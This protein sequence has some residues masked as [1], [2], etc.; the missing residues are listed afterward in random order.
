MPKRSC[1]SALENTQDSLSASVPPRFLL[2]EEN[3][4]SK[5]VVP[6]GFDPRCRWAG[7]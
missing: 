2:T 6:R 7:G 3:E 1:S 4:E 5:Q